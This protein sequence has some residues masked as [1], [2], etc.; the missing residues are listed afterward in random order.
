MAT[1]EDS[2]RYA[3]TEK[4]KDTIAR[5]RK[6]VTE[7]RKAL[8]LK[9]FAHDQSRSGFAAAKFSKRIYAYN[10]LIGTSDNGQPK[11]GL[12][13]RYRVKPSDEPQ[14]VQAG[15][16]RWSESILNPAYVKKLMLM[17]GEVEPDKQEK[18]NVRMRKVL[19]ELHEL[20]DG[21]CTP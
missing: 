20:L 4:G 18:L 14:C 1:S 13:T 11:Y 21:Q 10:P 5:K 19:G 6:T 12:A 8:A 15:I 9:K 17:L 3:A 16:P 7:K 2:K